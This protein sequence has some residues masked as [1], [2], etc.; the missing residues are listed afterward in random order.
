VLLAMKSGERVADAI[1]EK[2]QRGSMRALRRYARDSQVS[3]DRYFRFIN[4][5][6]QREFLEVFLSPDPPRG[7]FLPIVR[8]LGG[9]VASSRADRIRLAL[10]FTLVKLQKRWAFAPRIEWDALPAPASM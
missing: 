6:Y 9:N 7:F 1:A 5:F 2:L 10:F 3:I 8:V 4:Y